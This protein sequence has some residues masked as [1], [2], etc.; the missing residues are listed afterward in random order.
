MASPITSMIAA[1]TTSAELATARA[2]SCRS[3]PI[4]RDTTAPSPIDMP[5]EIESCSMPTA[6]AKPIAAV[7][8]RSPS[9]EM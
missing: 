3:A 7:S 2:S 4:S 1:I 9:R 5:I 6:L 8:A